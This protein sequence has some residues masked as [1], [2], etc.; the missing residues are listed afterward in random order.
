M[1]R[2]WR[3]CTAVLGLRYKQSLEQVGL[4][5]QDQIRLYDWLLT[6][7]GR[8]DWAETSNNDRL[9]RATTITNDQAFSWRAGLSYL[10]DNGVAPYVSY[11]TSFQPEI[12]VTAAGQ[13][14]VPSTG[15]QYEAGIK[16]QPPGT[17]TLITLAAF[18]ITRQN[19]VTFDP[20]TFLGFQTGE[21]KSRGFEVEGR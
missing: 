6:I 4:Y 17:D 18:D 2:L 20:V 16:Y 19:I 1:S 11:A 21:A 7:G 13:P 3:S 12:G 15:D 5:V 8:Q 10:F 14:F 9:A